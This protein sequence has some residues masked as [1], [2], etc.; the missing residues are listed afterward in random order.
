MLF[1][2]IPIYNEEENIIQ[3][4][5][6]IRKKLFGQN[7]KIIAVNDG[8]QDGSLKLLNELKGDD[9][10]IEGYCISMNVGA[11]FSTGLG[12]I[13]LESKDD[14]DIVIIMEGDGT[15]SIDLVEQFT[16]EIKNNHKD[17]VIASRYKKGGGYTNFPSSCLLF[18]YCANYFMHFYFPIVAVRDYTIFYRAY[19]VGI[20]KKA[21]KCFGKHGLIQF[22]GFVANAELLVKLSLIT[23]R[24]SEI[25]FL[26]DYAMKLGKSKIRV[27]R[28]INEYFV[29]VAYLKRTIKKYRLWQKS[30]KNEGISA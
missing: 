1:L 28:T 10:I 29:L 26:Y 5:S 12:R 17:I 2:L 19:R 22:H 20:L 8:S 16:H 30:Q 25:P 3:L 23:D 13:L 4:I 14:E 11:V 9:L 21:I 24:I 27:L 7:Y 6:E 18:S 15:S